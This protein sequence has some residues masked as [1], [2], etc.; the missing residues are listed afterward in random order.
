MKKVYGPEGNRRRVWGGRDRGKV[1]IMAVDWM[2]EENHR[3][4][5]GCGDEGR[6]YV[7]NIDDTQLHEH[8]VGDTPTLEPT[9]MSQP[10]TTPVSQPITTP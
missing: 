10:V 3:Q 8:S 1:N 6:C 4:G 5:G 9:P 2:E 7:R